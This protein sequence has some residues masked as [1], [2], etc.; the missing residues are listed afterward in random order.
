MTNRAEQIAE[1][2]QTIPKVYRTVYDRAVAGKSFVDAIKLQ[3]LSCCGQRMACRHFSNQT[4]SGGT[5]GRVRINRAQNRSQ[6]VR[7]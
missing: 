5:A 2:R 7:A 3:C 4:P 6:E 1:F